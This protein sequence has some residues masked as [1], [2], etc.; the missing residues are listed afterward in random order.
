MRAHAPVSQIEVFLQVEV[1]VS[2]WRRLVAVVT[3]QNE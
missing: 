3:V 2:K 1:S